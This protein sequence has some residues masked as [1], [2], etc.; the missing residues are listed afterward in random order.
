MKFFLLHGSVWRREPHSCHQLVIPEHRHFRLIKEAHNDLGYKGVFTVQTRLLLRFWWPM[1]VEDIKW[2]I[3]TCHKCQIRQTHRLHI[4]PTMSV[5]GGLF[6]KVHLD[7]MVMPRSAGYWYIVQAHCALTAYPKW[8]MLHS[9]NASTL[10]SFIFEDN[11]CCW[12]ALAEIVTD[13]GP[14]FVQAL[15]VLADRYNIRHIC[16]SPYNSQAN[17]VVEQRHLDVQ[18]AII[19]S[20]PGGE[21][22]W[23]TATHSVF[24]AERVTMLRS[25][26]LSPYFMVHSVEPLFPFDLAEA[27]FLI[28]PPDTE[29]LS[30]SRLIAWRAC[31]LQK[32]QEDLES[33]RERVLKARFEFVKHFE[34]AFKDQIKDYDFQAGSLVLV[35][36]TRIEKELNRKTKP[37][38]ILR[39]YGGP[40]P[41]YRRVIPTGRAGWSGIQIVL[42]CLSAYPLLFLPF[43]CY[44]YH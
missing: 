39:S 24:W 11:L 38:Y 16:I 37:W 10:A 7:T 15:D 32:R 30:S 19:K 6:R 20:T 43:I 9:E 36:N 2:F 14:A 1:L 29:P 35:R 26:S 8:Q 41:D 44:L 31:Q 28:P 21:F 33:I 34:A 5:I 22:C 13:N 42:C 4:P 27:T 40:S 18:E 23:H 3:R 17:G 12:S 25:T